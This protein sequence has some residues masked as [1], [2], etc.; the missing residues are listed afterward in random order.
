MNSVKQDEF[1]PGALEADIGARLKCIRKARKMTINELAMLANVSAGAISQIER[2]Q[3][4]PTVRVL[5]QLRLVLK[6]PLT[7]FLEGST[8]TLRGTEY[9]IRRL[10]ERP[11]FNVGRQ[12]IAKEMLSPAGD[13]A[14][15]FMFI[16]IPPGVRSD[17]MLMGQ[18]EKAGIIMS[19]ELTLEL[20]GESTILFPGDSFQFKSSL[21]H[22]IFNHTDKEARVLWIMHILPDHHL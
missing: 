10:A 4:N 1:G 9:Y 6:V 15:Q 8:A 21:K 2:N 12:G 19:G 3:A 17:E 16:V 22:N 18:G 13:H 7:A 11:H 14:V 20:E 5:E